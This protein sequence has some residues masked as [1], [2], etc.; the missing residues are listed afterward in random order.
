MQ[1]VET[2]APSQTDCVSF[3]FHLGHPPSKV[4]R[5]LTEPALLS[6]WL[7]PMVESSLDL[8]PGAAFTLEIPPQP[9]W[10]GRIEC[11]LLD[12][13]P[14]RRLRYTWV[15]DELDTVVTFTLTPT[16]QGTRLSLLHTGFKP[17]QTRNFGGARFG[18]KQMGERLVTVLGAERESGGPV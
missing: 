11:R 4:W 2:T 18:W 5:A 1:L 6:Q 7:M 14:P 12:V 10:T 9:G 8:V 16:P 3:D 13:D 17:Q 15:L